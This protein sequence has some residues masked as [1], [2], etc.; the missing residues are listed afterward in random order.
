MAWSEM[1]RGWPPVRLVAPDPY[2]KP[3]PGERRMTVAG[4]VATCRGMGALVVSEIAHTVVIRCS[5]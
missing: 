2:V 5:R 3:D 4:S 1:P